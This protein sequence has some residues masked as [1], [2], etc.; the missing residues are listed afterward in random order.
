MKWEETYD[1]KYYDTNKND[2]LG[3]SNIFVLCQETAMRQMEACKPSYEDL[4]NEGKAFIL[5]SMRVELYY[6]IYAYEKINVKTWASNN[7]K[8]FTTLRSYELYRDNELIGESSS[9]WALVSTND[10]RLLKISEVDFTDY[11]GEMPLTLDKPVKVRIPREVTLSLVGEYTVRYTDIDI[12]SHMNNSKY[13]DMLFNCLP[14]PNGK[15]IKSFAIT[16]A[17]EAK[18]NDNLKIY[19]AYTDGKYFMRSV[20]EDGRTN[21]EAEFE[22]ENID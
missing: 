20:L 7:N 16:F 22:V 3:I 4:F 2:M 12:N 5:S 11:E 6:P 21:V 14:N 18:L 19:V 17:N 15:M 10:K 13:P 9:T 1:I 8:G